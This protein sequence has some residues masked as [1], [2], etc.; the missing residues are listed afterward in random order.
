M[1]LH[2]TRQ[3]Q[4][5]SVFFIQNSADVSLSGRCFSPNGGQKVAR[6]KKLA[7]CYNL[8]IS[9]VNNIN[10]ILECVVHACVY[11]WLG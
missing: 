1:S 11:E 2:G 3:K 7:S 9:G 5:K 8:V 10:P 4:T 6:G